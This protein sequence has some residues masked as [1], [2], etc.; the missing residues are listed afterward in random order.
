MVCAYIILMAGTRNKHRA[1][2]IYPSDLGEANHLNENPCIFQ[3][4]TIYKWVFRFGLCQSKESISKQ[5]WARQALAGLP[6]CSEFL[7]KKPAQPCWPLDAPRVMAYR[8]FILIFCLLQLRGKPVIQSFELALTTWAHMLPGSSLLLV[9]R[10]LPSLKPIQG[11]TMPRDSWV[12]IVRHSSKSFLRLGGMVYQIS[13]VL[14]QLK[15]CSEHNL[16]L[17]TEKLKRTQGLPCTVIELLTKYLQ[18]YYKH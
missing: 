8:Y 7:E 13:S 11:S 5:W 12:L 15:Q 9:V 18:M 3:F 4:L 16:V 6:S 14:L 17:L 2:K 1:N 10:S